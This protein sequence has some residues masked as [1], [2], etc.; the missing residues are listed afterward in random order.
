MAAALWSRICPLAFGACLLIAQQ[1]ETRDPYSGDPPRETKPSQAYFNANRVKGIGLKVGE[2]TATS[3]IVWTRVPPVDEVAYRKKREAVAWLKSLFF[4]EDIQVRM[5]MGRRKDLS[6]ASW[7]IWRDADV[8]DDFT[9]RW[10]VDGLLP[11]TTYYV[12]IEGADAE[13]RPIYP[14]RRGSF[15]TAPAPDDPAPVVFTVVTGQRYDRLDHPDGFEIYPSMAQLNPSFAVLTGDTVYFDRGPLKAHT[16]ELARDRWRRL[17]ELPRVAD[18]H[19]SIP[20]YWEKD[21]HDVLRDDVS[22]YSRP[23]GQL[24][25]EDGLNLFRTYTPV[26]ERPY[27]RFRWGGLLEIWLTEVREFR[28]RNLAPD[29]PDKSILGEEQK[30]WLKETMASSDAVWRILVSPTPVVGP[31]RPRNKHDNHANRAWRT[32]GDELREFF[33]DELGDNSFIIAGDRHWQYHSVHPDTGVE[34]YACGPASDAH[35]GG[36][37]GYDDEYH[38]FHREGGGFLSVSVLRADRRDEAVIRLHGV[39]GSVA[40][41][42]RWS[43]DAVQ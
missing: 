1:S 11:G 17:Y 30:R 39:D 10:T 38:R 37:P 21:D 15:R 33:A 43:R 31:D 16:L 35:A 42:D 4:E 29:G 28:D 9:E 25:F 2:V 40:Y 14:I 18:F 12:E 8:E 7:R 20:A 13:R 5:R 27:R 6:D 23:Y 19:T 41:E 32:E 3:A 26:G 22:P 24:T 34:E 36:S